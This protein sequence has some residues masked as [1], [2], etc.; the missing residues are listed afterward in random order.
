MNENLQLN[1]DFTEQQYSP[2]VIPQTVDVTGDGSGGAVTTLNGDA[3]AGA[4]GPVVVFGGGS[5]GY[6]FTAV[7]SSVTM[8]LSNAATVRTGLSVPRIHTALVAPAITDDGAA[9]F[10]IGTLWV[11]T[12][13]DNGFMS[14]DAS[15]GAAVWKQITV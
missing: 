6:Q 13:L 15:A 14:V 12:V 10:P 2:S 11:D 5:T 9:G 3:G 4:V 7:G 1:S 8:T